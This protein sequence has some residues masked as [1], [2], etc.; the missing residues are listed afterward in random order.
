MRWK[1]AVK[2]GI[3]AILLTSL[4][5]ELLTGSIYKGNTEC[6]AFLLL[7]LDYVLQGFFQVRKCKGKSFGKQA[8]GKYT[9][10]FN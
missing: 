5:Y 2:I 10:S 7:R 4:F 1:E 9:L 8:F 6:I 3:I